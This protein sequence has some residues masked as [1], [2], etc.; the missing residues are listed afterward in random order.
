MQHCLFCSLVQEHFRAIPLLSPLHINHG[1]AS[2]LMMIMCMRL[3]CGLSILIWPLWAFNLDLGFQSLVGF[4]YADN[5]DGC[6][7][8]SLIQ[9]QPRKL[10]SDISLVPLPPLGMVKVPKTGSTTVSKI[11][12]NLASA[13]GMA[14]M[15]PADDHMLGWPG[16]FPGEANLALYGSPSHK[17][18][19]IAN[20]AVFNSEKWR[21]YLRSNP[22]F[23]AILREPI[24]QAV[25]SHNV[26]ARALSWEEHLTSLE[27]SKAKSVVPIHKWYGW[28]CNPQAYALGWYEYVG[29]TTKYDNNQTVIRQ[30]IDSLDFDFG[31][32]GSI[33]L[34]EYF[35]EGLVLLKERLRVKPAELAYQIQNA[36]LDHSMPSQDQLDR[37]RSLYPV[38]L[39]LYDHFNKTFWKHWQQAD[40]QIREGQLAAMK[41][42]NSE[43]NATC[44]A[45]ACPPVWT[46]AN[47]VHWTAHLRQLAE[48][49][50]RGPR[51]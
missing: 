13:R 2:P 15:F 24:S 34:T 11:M 17:Y 19:L 51:V 46:D 12:Q 35:D 6:A 14:I 1:W 33:I 21:G 8:F 31:H 49:I 4:E 16:A 42:A 45:G 26:F 27:M 29:R 40:P 41:L 22:V 5:Y 50:E 37:L 43:L 20:H 30:W 36:G 44:N 3:A 25:S 10:N 48:R 38:D 39:V 28:F 7:G 47:A 9:V 18:E 32:S 23:V